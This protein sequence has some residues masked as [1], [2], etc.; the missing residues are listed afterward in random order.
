MNGTKR[1]TFVASLSCIALLVVTAS[2]GAAT[3]RGTGGADTL[4]GGA[5]SDKLDGKS[6]N[7]KLYGAAGNDVLLG[8]AGNDLLVGGPGA[9]RLA[10]GAGLDVARGD[11]QDKIAKDCE[12]V[13]GVPT[14][15]PPPTTPP[16]PP[17]PPPATPVTPGTY[18]GLLEGNFIFFEV[19][20]DRT[21]SGFR[22]NYIREDC[23]QG[24][25]IYGTVGWGTTK[26][27]I[28]A[29]GTFS[30]GGPS[31]G[32]VDDGPATF[33]DEVKGRFDGNTVTGTIIGTA[34]FDYDGT[35]YKCSSGTK[36][37]TATL[38]P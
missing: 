38:E 9:D 19:G 4:R 24:G 1:S 17:P 35:H 5:A 29:D 34:E 8:G 6:G 31:T 23:E 37:W 10:C 2:V 18:K 11:A 32:T 33:F 22:S 21:I 7:D 28:A 16:P 13:K 14:T 15:Q 27:P 36:S 26:Y 30:F 25:Y 3:I 12:T 20:G